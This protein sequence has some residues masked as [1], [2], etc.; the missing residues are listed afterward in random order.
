MEAVFGPDK[1]TDIYRE[2]S[3]KYLQSFSAEE[4]T[5]QIVLESK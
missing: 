2:W 3:T 5:G 1:L 4:F